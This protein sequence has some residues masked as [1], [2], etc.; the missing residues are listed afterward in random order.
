MAL[1]VVGLGYYLYP[2]AAIGEIPEILVLVLIVIYEIWFVMLPR[3]RDTGMSAYWLILAF[4]PFA[5][6]FLSCALMFRR[7]DPRQ[8]PLWQHLN[9]PVSN[10]APGKTS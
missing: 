1:F 2:S 6:V 7:S 9:M 4:I 3:I 5:N 8:N 10:P